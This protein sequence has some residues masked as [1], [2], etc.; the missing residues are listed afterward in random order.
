MIFRQITVFFVLFFT[1]LFRLLA[2]DYSDLIKTAGD[3]SK[4]PN[5]PVL[6]I[7]DSTRVE[8]MESGL[9]HFHLHLLYKALTEKGAFDLSIQKFGYEPMSMFMSVKKV[10]IYRND[11]H[12]EELAKDRIFDYPA[13]ASLILWGARE[14][15]IAIGRLEPGEAVEIEIYKKGYTYALL[16][17]DEDKYIPPMRGHYYD[18][19]PFWSSWQTLEKVYQTILPSAKLLQ[20]SFYNGEI[21]PVVRNLDGKICYSFCKKNISPLEREPNM[22]DPFDVA[23]KLILTTAPD[24]P[25]KSRWFYKVNEDYG[26]FQWTPDIKA[27]TDE[28]LKGA[29]DELDSVSRLTHWVADNIRYFG[30][31]MGCGEG[32][33]LHKAEMTFEDRCGVCKDKAGMLVTMLRAAGFEAYAAMTMAGSRIEN[34]P[35]DHFNHSVT[36]VRLSDGQLHMLDPTWVP[37][38]RELW[39]SREQQQNYIIG[40]PKGEQLQEIPVSPAKNHYFNLTV[41]SK[42]HEDGS[43]S[44]KL[45]LIAEGQSDAA[46]RS[47]LT[48][49][50][51]N[52]WERLM[53]TELLSVFP[54]MTI[55]KISFSD[56]YDYNEPFRLEAVFHIGNFANVVDNKFIFTPFS[57]TA[58]YKNFHPHLKIN[59]QSEKKKYGFRDACS[60]WIEI[61]ETMELPFSM[62]AVFIPQVKDIEGTPA[63]FFSS[64]QIKDKTL[65]FKENVS[66]NKRVYEKEDWPVFRQVVNNQVRLAASKIILNKITF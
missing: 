61:Y 11:G 60:K 17:E 25:S 47:S 62:N 49:T 53:E 21:T 7:F 29:K 26:S 56:A 31:N 54:Q 43:L 36:A 15:M 3:A 12:I 51:R 10:K 50:F 23:P 8:V 39:S 5:S 37:F 63:S 55:E 66:L 24:W 32:Y 34:I 38:V 57:A 9:S 65:I 6:V 2:A 48:R 35:A 1:L 59:L 19:V 13:P 4:Y 42:L 14:Q 40:T 41:E 44:G 33:T 30:L 27:K 18:I 20:Y 45:F 46:F 22:V 52:N 58:I 16:E 28:I 64:F